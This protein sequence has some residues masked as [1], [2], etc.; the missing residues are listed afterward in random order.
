MSKGTSNNTVIHT[1][2]LTRDYMMQN[3][4][5]RAV[6]NVNI[7]VNSGEFVTFMGRSGS[8]KTTLLNLISGLDNPTKGKVFFDGQDI[9]K[10]S[11]KQMMFMRRNKFGIIFQSFS[12]LPLL[13]AYENVELPLRI[14]GVKGLKRKEMTNSAMEIVGLSHRSKHRPYELSG[15]EQQRIAIARSIVNN[16]SVILADEPTGELD[17]INSEKIFGIFKT[18]VEE[19][20]ITILATTHDRTLLNL[21]HRVLEISDGKLI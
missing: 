2:N 11:E 15:G 14:S 16:P 21:S 1:E 19:K 13:S 6:N 8:G 17:S 7:K 3:Q 9:H 20:K 18:M 10:I 5:I 12:L 4:T